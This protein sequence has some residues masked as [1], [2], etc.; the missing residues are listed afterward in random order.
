MF[1]M[2]EKMEVL[3]AVEPHAYDRDF[4]AASLRMTDAI[5]A[6]TRMSLLRRTCQLS[7]H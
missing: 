2:G 6:G 3:P 4:H 1:D 5:P 7:Q